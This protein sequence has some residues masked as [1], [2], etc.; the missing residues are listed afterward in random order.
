MLAADVR[1]GQRE[2]LAQKIRKVE[3]RRHMRIDALA[4]DVQ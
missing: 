4:V 2:M 3:A 1:P